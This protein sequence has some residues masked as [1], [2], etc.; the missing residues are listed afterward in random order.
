LGQRHGLS[1][2]SSSGEFT[3][4]NASIFGKLHESPQNRVKAG[5]NT[6]NEG[7]EHDPENWVP[8]SRLREARDTIRRLA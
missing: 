7:P 8:V 4:E 2:V 5:Q 1:V 6:A 3:R